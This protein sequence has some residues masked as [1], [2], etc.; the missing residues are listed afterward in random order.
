[1]VT[2][3]SQAFALSVPQ[4][5][6]LEIQDDVGF[7][8]AVRAVLMKS[9]NGGGGGGARSEDDVEHAI[10]QIVSGASRIGAGLR[11]S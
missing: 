2:Q 9:G 1:M 4:P 8:Q 5:E 6:A 10:R 11:P 3:L 7:F